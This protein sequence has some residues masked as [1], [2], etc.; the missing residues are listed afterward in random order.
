MIFAPHPF[1]DNFFYRVLPMFDCVYVLG[2]VVGM[3]AARLHGRFIK[4]T[5]YFAE[6]TF[7]PSVISDQLDPVKKTRYTDR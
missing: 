6:V 3:V 1:C 5:N 2:G 7:V 4:E